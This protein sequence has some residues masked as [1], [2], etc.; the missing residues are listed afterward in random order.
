M[1]GYTRK[2]IAKILDMPE[3]TINYYTER[4][5][6]IPEVD[7][8]QGRGAVRR[9]SKKNVV[10]LG[11]LKQLAGYGLSFKV[12][13][14]IFSTLRIPL[15][16]FE[17]LKLKK[18]QIKMDRG[19]IIGHWQQF[20]TDTYIILYLMDDGNFKHQI[21]SEMPLDESL[22]KDRMKNSGSVLIINVGRIASLVK[23]Q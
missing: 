14:S 1:E 18:D 9:Y 19:G 6:V 13:D 21:S 22:N 4:K 23:A 2:Q 17:D 10:E 16:D 11:I 7:E 3:R 8:G 20:K 5:V 15:P 12:V